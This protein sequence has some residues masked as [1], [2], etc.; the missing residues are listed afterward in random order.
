[1]FCR[2]CGSQIKDGALF[3]THCGQ[4]VGSPSSVNKEKPKTENS[5]AERSSIPKAVPE[6]VKKAG[7]SKG[8]TA[9]ITTGVLAVVIAVPV[10][11][12][13]PGRSDKGSKDPSQG[14]SEDAVTEEL[15]SKMDETTQMVPAS[16]AENELESSD[17]D[18]D[19]EEEP[20]ISVVLADYQQYVNGLSE[21]ELRFNLVYIDDDDVPECII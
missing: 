11:I 16:I 17:R 18:V 3:C 6:P 12:F 2:K 14:Y 8:L 5:S 20:D 4:R 21:D 1:M 9:A 19:E 10:F 7:L 13:L 15:S